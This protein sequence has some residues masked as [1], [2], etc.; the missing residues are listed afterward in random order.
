MNKE[1]E[2]RFLGGNAVTFCAIKNGSWSFALSRQG[3]FVSLQF[4]LRAVE[5]PSKKKIKSKT[6]LLRQP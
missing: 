4:I 3:V 5:G 1:S 6:D 2:L